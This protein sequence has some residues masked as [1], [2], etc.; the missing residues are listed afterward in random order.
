MTKMRYYMLRIFQKKG[1]VTTINLM[2]CASSGA[3]VNLTTEG[4]TAFMLVALM[5]SY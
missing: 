2:C 4:G 3:S 1:Y 5:E